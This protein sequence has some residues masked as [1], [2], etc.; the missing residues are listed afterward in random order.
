VSR[1]FLILLFALQAVPPGGQA[2][3]G[4]AAPAQGARGQGGR[5]AGPAA[6]NPNAVAPIEFVIEPPTLINLGFEW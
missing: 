2:Q 3:R 6:Q 4:N 5:G 1:L